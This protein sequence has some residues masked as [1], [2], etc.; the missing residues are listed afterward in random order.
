MSTKSLVGTSS[1][2]IAASAKNELFMKKITTKTYKL[3][4]L[5]SIKEPL[6]PISRNYTNTSG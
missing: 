6:V 4:S 3:S 2:N 1:P 5:G